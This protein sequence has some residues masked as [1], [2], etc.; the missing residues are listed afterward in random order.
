MYI[1]A[2][3][4][5]GGVITISII[6]A[7]ATAIVRKYDRNLLSENGRP[8]TINDFTDSIL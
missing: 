5:A 3:R 6:I 1:K 7:A 8:I 2:V 4:E